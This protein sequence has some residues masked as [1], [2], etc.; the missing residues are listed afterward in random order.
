MLRRRGDRGR[1]CSMVGHITRR[2]AQQEESSLVPAP[3]VAQVQPN[4]QE[5][6]EPIPVKNPQPATQGGQNQPGTTQQSAQQQAHLSE[7]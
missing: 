5:V 6:P 7:Q 1:G 2:H 4:A 3:V